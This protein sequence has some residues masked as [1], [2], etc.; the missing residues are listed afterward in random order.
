MLDRPVEIATDVLGDMRIGASVI[1][2]PRALASAS[3]SPFGYSLP[4][5]L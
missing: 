2:T 1:G 4:W 3:S 5:L